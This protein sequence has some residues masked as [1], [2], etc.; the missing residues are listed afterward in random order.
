[1]TVRD[2][3]PG[4]QYNRTKTVGIN[5]ITLSGVDIRQLLVTMIIYEDLF[6]H[7][8]TI[9]LT[10][11]DPIGMTEDP[12]IFS[13]EDLVIS[14]ES[15]EGDF[16]AY[17]KSFK[18]YK[19][20]NMTN[21]SEGSK[22]KLYTIHGTTEGAFANIEKR[23][24]RCWKDLK[25]DEIVSDICQNVLGIKVETETCL[26]DRYFVAPNIRP[27]SV[28][29]EMCRSAVRQNGYPTCNYIFYEDKHGHK[30]KS[31]DYLIEQGKSHKIRHGIAA[32]VSNDK[33]A[34]LNARSYSNINTYDFFKNVDQGMYGT[35]VFYVDLH[36][37]KEYDYKD[38]IYSGEFGGQAKIDGAND[39]LMKSPPGFPEQKI[40]FGS[41]HQGPQ[42]PEYSTHFADEY[43]HKRL[44]IMQ[45]FDNNGYLVDVDG[46]TKVELGQIVEFEL[47]SYDS[48]GDKGGA[49][50][51]KEDKKYSKNYLVAQIRHHVNQEEHRM[52]LGL[53]K[54]Q[55]KSG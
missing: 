9:E 11:S 17:S 51:Q 25:E 14:F 22:N 52:I 3:Y 41:R 30:F 27:V 13:K 38:Y 4:D 16:P 1:M 19:I 42:P 12:G 48:R 23:A 39:K 29:Q 37:K 45:Q 46:D 24:S 36:G 6:A 10:I 32:Q 28:I 54:H 5:T 31:I 55:L 33:Y 44:S 7:F 50:V 40:M 8:T 20:D 49:F 26:N 15:T 34:R 53:I 35:R 18:V 21:A 47:P 2:T 43:Q